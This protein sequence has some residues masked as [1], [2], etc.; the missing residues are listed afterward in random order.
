MAQHS[1]GFRVA[2][3]RPSWGNHRNERQGCGCR[4]LDLAN[5]HETINPAWA[6]NEALQQLAT[7]DVRRTL[8]KLGG[9]AY[10][11]SPV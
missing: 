3:G 6:S 9:K 7:G 5:S 8:G 10:G 4:G 11:V 1:V 2:H